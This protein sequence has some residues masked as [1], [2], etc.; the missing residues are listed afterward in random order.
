MIIN[1]A[2]GY[3]QF[4]FFRLI[5]AKHRRCLS[6]PADVRERGA[7]SVLMNMKEP[8]RR[9]SLPVE[10]VQPAPAR[11]SSQSVCQSVSSGLGCRMATV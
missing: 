2:A 7:G 4:Y 11:A 8:L 3:F 6:D 10:L 9:H 1:K 5:P